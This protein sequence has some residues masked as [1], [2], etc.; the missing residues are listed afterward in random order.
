MRKILIALLLLN[1]L[2]LA[3]KSFTFDNSGAMIWQK[4]YE[5]NMTSD[6][7]YKALHMCSHLQ[8]IEKVDSTFYV[9][10]MKRSKIDYEALGY[11]RMQLPLYL[12]NTDIGS[13]TVIIQYKE[14]KYKITLRHIYLSTLTSLEYGYLEEFAVEGEGR[15]ASH[16]KE[17]AGYIYHHYFSKW[18]ELEKISDEW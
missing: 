7:L 8:S 2:C 6:E 14:G 15:F 18:F 9:A 5:T 12:S 13:A 16:F 17:A 10:K 11:K 1:S 3:G 4:V